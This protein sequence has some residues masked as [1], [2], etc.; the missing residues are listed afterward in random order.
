MGRY[1]A[2][3][4]NAA[5]VNA[6]LRPGGVIRGPS[7]VLD[8][9]TQSATLNAPRS[10]AAALSRGQIQKLSIDSF[11]VKVIMRVSIQEPAAGPD[12]VLSRNGIRGCGRNLIPGFGVMAVDRKR[13]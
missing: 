5:A 9:P 8:Q 13:P 4:T 2:A 11:F 12:E 10:P 1:A 7:E 3:R 6:A